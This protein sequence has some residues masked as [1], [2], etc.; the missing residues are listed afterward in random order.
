MNN[1]RLHGSPIIHIA[2]LQGWI[3]LGS[4]N[5]GWRFALPWAITFRPVGAS[6]ELIFF[7]VGRE[8]NRGWIF[9]VWGEE[10]GGRVMV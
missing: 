7:A 4:P 2:P 5:P 10:N 1:H 3:F 9:Q 8:G 6:E